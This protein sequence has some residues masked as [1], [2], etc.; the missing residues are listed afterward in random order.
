[1][2]YRRIKL[3]SDQERSEVTLRQMVV[4]LLKDQVDIV[5][6]ESPVGE[7]ASNGEVENAI[8]QV[9]GMTRTLKDLIEAYGPME[10]DPTHNI[11]PWMVEY[12]AQ[13]LS[14]YKVGEDGKTPYERIK[15]KKF[16]TP[17]VTFGERVRFLKSES[18]GKNKWDCRW[19]HG[20][21]LGI[22]ET[23]GEYLLGTK[24][25]GLGRGDVW[26]TQQGHVRNS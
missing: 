8:K 10:I 21:F 18:V 1:L 16:K 25:G 20:I 15:G 11:S 14:R 3:K 2:G 26:Q 22:R 9:Q 4:R 24:E 5:P 17:L 23:S 19:S 12:A 6:E 7:H 13:L